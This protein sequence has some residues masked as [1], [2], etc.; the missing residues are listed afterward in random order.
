MTRKAA[1]AGNPNCGKTTLFNA[2]TGSDL[3]V[4]N[5]PGVTVEKREATFDINGLNAVLTDLPGAYSLEPY[6]IE[7]TVTRDYLLSDECEVV[8]NIVDAM[9]LERGLYL[10]SQLLRLR[11]PVILCVNMSDELESEGGRLDSAALS[12]FLGCPVVM[13]SAR[14]RTGFDELF[15]DLYSAFT[16]PNL[17]PSPNFIESDTEAHKWIALALKSADYSKRASGRG[18]ITERL[19]KI[20]TGKYTAF[21]ILLLTLSVMF[22]LAFGPVGRLLTDFTELV[23]NGMG[24]LIS[25]AVSGLPEWTRSFIS[26]GVFAGAGGVMC[27]LPQILILFAFMAII[28]DTGYMARAAFVTD[29]LLKKIGLSGRSAIP[30]LM[31]LGCTTTAAALA[32][33]VENERDRRLTVML[34]PCMSCAAK[35]P[36]YTAVAVACFPNF[37]WTAI[38]SLY[39]LGVLVMGV[40]GLVYKKAAFKSGETQFLMELP[41]Y[42]LPVFSAVMRRIK[43]RTVD[44]IKRAGSVIVLLSAVMWFFRYF[45]PSLSPAASMDESIIAKVGMWL[46]P[47]FKPLGFGSWQA[48]A[49]LFSG[50]VAK[51]GVLSTLQ[52][53]FRAPNAAALTSS[54]A[55][56]LSGAAGGYAYLAFI[57]LYPPCCSAIAAI[58]RE[59]R[60]RR[61]LLIMLAAQ[62]ISAYI[63]S[64]V[65]Y[66]ALRLFGL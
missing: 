53:L 9:N 17:P 46:A 3:R 21:P 15:S 35:L 60:S 54:I 62:T 16:E 6:S 50:L 26:D 43:I 31:G 22:M 25:N 7:E 12:K 58:R 57:L 44:F 42:R 34:T 59:L 27:F 45:D 29:R 48:V 28:E 52:V 47:I 13:L 49:G 8:I 36:V 64:L 30:M 23:I 11:K 19:D 32:R 61:L 10:T 38:L 14:R 39:A 41:T 18:D 40:L 37:A 51:E 5:W 1:L 55:A 24:A 63:V 33:S 20:F 65:L 56:N 4:G 66:N 2:L